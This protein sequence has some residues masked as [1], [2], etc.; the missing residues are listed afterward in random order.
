TGSSFNPILSIQSGDAQTG[1]VSTPLAE[2]L[3][4]R[5]SQPNANKSFGGIEIQWQVI[6]G[7][8]SIASATSLTDAQ[9][10][11]RNRLT[12]GPNAGTNRVTASI[13]SGDSVTFIAIGE[14]PSGSLVLVSGDGQSLPTGVDSAPLV[15]ELRDASGAPIANQTLLWS[16]DNA[17]LQ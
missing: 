13:A 9:G 7:D 6:E 2:D 8:G 10:L 17:E 15:V 4:V 1:L 14:L 5:L 12:L 3:V 11:A 16:G